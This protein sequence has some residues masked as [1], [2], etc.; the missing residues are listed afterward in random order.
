MWGK[1]DHQ[2]AALCIHAQRGPPDLSGSRGAVVGTVTPEANALTVQAQ[3]AFEDLHRKVQSRRVHMTTINSR[4]PHDR[5][6]EVPLA[7]LNGL[8]LRIV[9]DYPGVVAGLWSRSSDALAWRAPQFLRRDVIGAWPA[10]KTRTATVPAAILHHLR[11]IM[12]P[13]AALTKPVARQRCLD[14]VPK[15]YPAAFNQAWKQLD[16]SYKRG[17]GK[18]GKRR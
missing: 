2:K 7:E 16:A 10:P 11:Q 3:D 15:A 14:E 5:Q 1:S 6:V 9:P 12:T 8:Q 18:H 17:R 4:D 13:E